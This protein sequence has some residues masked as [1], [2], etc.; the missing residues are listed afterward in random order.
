[1]RRLGEI[2]SANVEHLNRLASVL[3]AQAELA[4]TR[5]QA[6]ES[7]RLSGQAAA[8]CGRV[9]GL[10]GSSLHGQA[11]AHAL[12]NLAMAQRRAGAW[13]L[14]RRTLLRGREVLLRLRSQGRLSDETEGYRLYLPAIEKALKSAQ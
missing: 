5:A 10:T 11:Y 12:Y 7:L 6:A 8:L 2:D 3:E 13:K 9:W 1:M 4:A 14:G